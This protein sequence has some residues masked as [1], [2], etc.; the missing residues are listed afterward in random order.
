MKG[1]FL[2]G[3]LSESTV[4]PFCDTLD[5]SSRLIY[6]W[7]NAYLVSDAHPV[8]PGHMLIVT[9]NHKLSFAEMG[10]GALTAMT[11]KIIAVSKLLLELGSNVVL[12]EHGNKTLNTSGKPSIDH[13]HF[14]L[15]PTTDISYLLPVSKQKAKFLDLPS[16]LIEGSYY[17]Y[18]DIFNNV[19]YWGKA[20]EIEPQ[21][22]RKAVA[23][24]CGVK[25]WNWRNN[26]YTNQQLAV[27]HDSLKSLFERRGNNGE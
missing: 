8:V 6:E 12:F 27:H 11:L 19:A 1:D 22:I 18:W 13:A 25:D 26:P 4:C 21:F 20:S 9:K 7:D 2:M 14:H 10:A 24:V 16:Y 15:I 23:S 5:I 3:T 17:F